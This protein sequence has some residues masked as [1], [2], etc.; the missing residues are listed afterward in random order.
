M[1]PG[2]VDMM[3]RGLPLDNL[4]LTPVRTLGQIR[5][6]AEAT[7]RNGRAFMRGSLFYV[8]IVWP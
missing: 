5:K 1:F 3:L 7:R 4:L 6:E 8:L 2:L